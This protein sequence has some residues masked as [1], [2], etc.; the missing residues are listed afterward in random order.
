MYAIE[1]HHPEG[2]DLA[3][4]A[5]GKIRAFDDARVAAA[6]ADRESIADLPIGQWGPYYRIRELPEAGATI[7]TGGKGVVYQRIRKM[8]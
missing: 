8:Y 5:D 3:R 7:E 6:T 1:W 4:N 2:N